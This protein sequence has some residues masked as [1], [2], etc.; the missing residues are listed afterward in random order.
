MTVLIQGLYG[1]WSAQVS[2]EI[3]SL[4]D[5][6]ELWPKKFNQLLIFASGHGAI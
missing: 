5:G 6:I 4:I 3:E 2:R 1:G